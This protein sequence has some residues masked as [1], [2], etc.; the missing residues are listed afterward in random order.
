ML[1]RDYDLPKAICLPI[2]K[3]KLRMLE[4]L[5][6]SPV[7]ELLGHSMLLNK[8]IFILKTEMLFSYHNRPLEYWSWQIPFVLVFQVPDKSDYRTYAA[9]SLMQL[10][11]KLPCAEYADF[12]GWLYRYSHNT[13]VSGYPF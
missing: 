3:D 11:N 7:L 2:G 10:L 6:A 1:L 12:I 5:V 13:K 9:Q 4:F 8:L